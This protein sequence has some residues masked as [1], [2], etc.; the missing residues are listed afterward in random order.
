M[1]MTP[2]PRTNK[3]GI[4][5]FCVCRHANNKQQGQGSTC[6]SLWTNMLSS[7]CNKHSNKFHGFVLQG[8]CVCAEAPVQTNSC[9]SILHAVARPRPSAPQHTLPLPAPPARRGAGG[10]PGPSALAWMVFTN[11]VIN[12]SVVFVFSTP[13]VLRKVQSSPRPH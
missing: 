5:R 9:Q 7:V 6:Q 10:G 11:D 1:R 4:L 13:L 3:Y 2:S 8:A 12:I